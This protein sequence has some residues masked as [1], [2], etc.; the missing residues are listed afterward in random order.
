M[1]FNKHK[2]QRKSFIYSNYLELFDEVLPSEGLVESSMTIFSNDI[3]GRSCAK[4]RSSCPISSTQENGPWNT[5][6]S[7]MFGKNV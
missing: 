4:L 7:I 6:G 2:L 3:R 5:L 1:R